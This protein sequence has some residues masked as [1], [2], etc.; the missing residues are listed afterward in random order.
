LPPH[1]KFESVKNPQTIGVSAVCAISSGVIAMAKNVSLRPF[2]SARRARAG[3]E[4]GV[5]P[6]H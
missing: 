2:V 5:A 6:T 3:V 4:T 1:R